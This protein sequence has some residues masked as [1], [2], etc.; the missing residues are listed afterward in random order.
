MKNIGF[1]RVKNYPK[2][3]KSHFGRVKKME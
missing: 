2:T 3:G 1:G